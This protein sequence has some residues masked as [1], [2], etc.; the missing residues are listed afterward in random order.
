[1]S[2]HFRCIPPTSCVRFRIVP[3]HAHEGGKH[4][5]SKRRVPAKAQ[6]REKRHSLDQ[7]EQQEWLCTRL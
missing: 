4:V 6:G 7:K 1:M 2:F 5:S 3:V